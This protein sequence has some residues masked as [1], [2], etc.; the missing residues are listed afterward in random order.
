MRHMASQE[1]F[2]TFSQAVLADTVGDDASGK[3]MGYL[4]L[5][6]AAGMVVGNATSH[7]IICVHG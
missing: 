7:Q 1:A 4:C 5:T 6:I 2:L 3:V